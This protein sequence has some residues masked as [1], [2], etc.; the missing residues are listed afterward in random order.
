M[1]LILIR[2]GR[3]EWNAEARVQGRTD[4]PLDAVGRA[5]AQSIAKRLSSIPLK[6]IYTSPLL[7]AAET[8]QEIAAYHA[9][10]VNRIAEMTEINF[11]AWEGKTAQEL[12]KQYA[13]LWQ[14]WNWILHPETCREMGAESADDILMRVLNG[15][16]Q[17]LSEQPED[18]TVALI[19]HTM[20]IKLLVAHL[21]G[22]PASKIRALKLANCS[23]TE[24]EQKAEHADCAQLW[25]WNDV[26]HLEET[27]ARRGEAL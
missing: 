17:M 22:L 16:D 8:A 27:P 25:V 6:A 13:A 24:L 2:H 21:I 10:S 3:T 9:C 7:R 18:A 19:S 4:I 11:G 26:S 20:P 5:Q 14:D 23:Y 12:E 1:R 15:L